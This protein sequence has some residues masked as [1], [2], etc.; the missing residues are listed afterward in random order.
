MTKSKFSTL[1]SVYRKEKP[2]YFNSA[3]TS[4][5]DNQSIKPNQI[6][7]VI[8]GDIPKVLEKTI[9]RWKFRLGEVLTI[10][11]L[12]KNLGLGLALSK[13]LHCCK[14]N[15]V[16]RMD[17]DDIA[18]RD[19]FKIQLSFLEANP[20]VVLSSSYVD[21]FNEEPRDLNV[22]KKVPIDFS[23]IKKFS[24]TRSPINHMSAVFKKDIILKCGNYQHLPNYED[25]YLWLKVLDSQHKVMNQELVLVYARVGNKMLERRTGLKILIR[26]YQFQRKV[27]EENLISTPQFLFNIVT[28][29]P[30]RIL[31]VFLLRLIYKLL[32]NFT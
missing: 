12:P 5:W 26:E 11:K 6:V 24:K 4:I 9:E 20:D 16:F 14:Y 1:I 23:K 10:K 8:D 15:I 21:E 29:L 19:R 3:F 32:R 30:V 13:G 22:I 27:L 28:R 25:Y 7:L 17:T 31:P 2:E 18:V